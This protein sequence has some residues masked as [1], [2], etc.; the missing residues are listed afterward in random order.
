VA[1]AGV[2]V[3][4]G[5]RLPHAGVGVDAVAVQPGAVGGWLRFG[6]GRRLGG[7]VHGWGG[8]FLVGVGQASTPIRGWGPAVARGG[9]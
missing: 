7:D 4:Q 5:R 9:G 2:V 8:L 6:V 1:V 3:E